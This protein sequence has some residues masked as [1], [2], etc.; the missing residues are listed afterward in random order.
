MGK[1]RA[2][3]KERFLWYSQWGIGSERPA[4]KGTKKDI[5]KGCSRKGSCFFERNFLVCKNLLDATKEVK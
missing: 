2:P 1:R 5:C 4:K 3:K